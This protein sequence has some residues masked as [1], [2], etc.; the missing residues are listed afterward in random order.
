LWDILGLL[1]VR[2][3]WNGF[4]FPY[5][6]RG[7]GELHQS[8]YKPAARFGLGDKKQKWAT[9]DSNITRK[10]LK[11]RWVPIKVVQ[12]PVQLCRL[13]RPITVGTDGNHRGMV[14]AS[15]CGASGNPSDCAKLSC[16]SRVK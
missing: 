15:I 10:A 6:R 1:K 12:N 3:G 4:D 14:S 8:C 7:G 9:R 2:R 11:N 13:D 16:V 5:C